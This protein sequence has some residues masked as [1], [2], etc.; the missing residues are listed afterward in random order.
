VVKTEDAI[1]RESRV[2]FQFFVYGGC[3][4]VVAGGG[5]W[6]AVGVWIARRVV[7]DALGVIGQ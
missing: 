3:A 2:A 4:G 7:L 1:R 5:C 6:V